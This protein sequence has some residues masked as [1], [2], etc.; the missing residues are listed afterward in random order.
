LPKPIV[1]EDLGRLSGSISFMQNLKSL[2]WKVYARIARRYVACVV[3]SRGHAPLERLWEHT[4]RLGY[5]C[6]SVV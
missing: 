3:G 5:I 1:E 6:H 2:I 4:A